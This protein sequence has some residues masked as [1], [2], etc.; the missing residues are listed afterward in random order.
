MHFLKYFIKNRV[1]VGEGGGGS[2]DLSPFWAGLGVQF[3]P[4]Y[5]LG[6]EAVHGREGRD[7]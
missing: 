6:T 3:Y 4:Q 7:T 1:F 2:E 5:D